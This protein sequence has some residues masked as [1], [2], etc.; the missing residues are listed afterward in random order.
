M[1]NAFEAEEQYLTLQ[2]AGMRSYTLFPPPPDAYLKT[3]IAL[4]LEELLGGGI[5]HGRT[6]FALSF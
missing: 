1:R 2:E 5:S 6:P 4:P 3:C